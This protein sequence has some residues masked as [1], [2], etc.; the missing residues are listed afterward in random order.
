MIIKFKGKNRD[1][2]L[3]SVRKIRKFTGLMF[4]TKNTE[5]LLFN[6]SEFESKNIHSF[7]VFF[8]F[9]AIWLNNRNKVLKVDLV[10]PFTILIKAPEKTRKLIEL[11]I[12]NS[13]KDLIEFFVDK[14]EKFK[15]P[16][17]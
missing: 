7:F 17:I 16:R 5:N 15:Y 1:I 14:R 13:N 11:P 6:F 9:M 10:K 8:D 2:K 4:R 12:N 3:K